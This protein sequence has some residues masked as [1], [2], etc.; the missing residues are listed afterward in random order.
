MRAKRLIVFALFVLYAA[1][2][3]YLLFYIRS[4]MLNFYT[5]GEYFRENTNFVPFR[6]I[7]EFVRYF[8]ADDAVYGELSFD[9][10][11]GNLAVFMP[12]GIFFPALWKKQ[13][14][15]GL[16]A[17]T[18]AAVII[19]AEIVQFLTMRGS[20]DIDDFIL[21]ISGAF[22]GFAFTKLNIVKKLIFT[23]ISF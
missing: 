1:A 6:T 22:I 10:L 23:D 13:R 5:Y 3:Y 18:I 20:C 15:F 17:L 8:R 2:V 4:S 12:A 14:S 19:G 9:N 21:N 11:W 16:F 7:I